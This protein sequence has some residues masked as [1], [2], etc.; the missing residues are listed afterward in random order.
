MISFCIY[1]PEQNK[2]LIRTCADT[3]TCRIEILFFPIFNRLKCAVFFGEF[4]LKFWPL[5]L[6]VLIFYYIKILEKSTEQFSWNTKLQISQKPYP[7]S[8]LNFFIYCSA[9]YS[10]LTIKFLK[11]FDRRNSK[12][13]KKNSKITTILKMSCYHGN[14]NM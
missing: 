11:T 4:F 3:D 2:K 13:S 9:Y 14:G 1:R 5:N 10:K 12:I 6:K 7:T 8:S